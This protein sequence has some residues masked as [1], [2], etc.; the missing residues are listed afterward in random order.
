M[1]R[2]FDL[3]QLN[4]FIT[5]AKCGSFSRAAEQLCITQPAL[6]R[7]IR[8]LEESLGVELFNRHGRGVVVTVAGELLQVRAAQLLQDGETIREEIAAVAGEVTG[9]VT[10]GLI[11]SVSHSLVGDIIQQYRETFPKV[12]LVVEEAMSGTLQELTEQKKIDLAITYKPYQG[13]LLHC[14]SLITEQL[15]LIGPGDSSIAEFS[16]ISLEDALQYP[17]ALPSNNHGLRNILERAAADEHLSLQ[18]DIEVNTLPWQIDIVQRG[19]AY[20]VLPMAAVRTRAKYGEVVACPIVSPK[21]ERELVLATATDSRNSMACL[22][23]QQMIT[24][25]VHRQVISGEWIG[26]ELTVI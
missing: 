17:I 16:D 18:L 11:P 6:S 15:Y 7:Q 20:T 14:S 23:L 22:K 3:H 5:V 9:R 19:L 12:S 4:S 2:S 13:R 26:A 21:L 1:S 8:T 25:E 10:L 24:N